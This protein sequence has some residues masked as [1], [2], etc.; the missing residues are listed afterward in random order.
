MGQF[1]D[2]ELLDF[3]RFWDL[4]DPDPHLIL[5]QLIHQLRGIIMESLDYLHFHSYE[6]TIP[7][8]T[9]LIYG[10]TGPDSNFGCSKADLLQSAMYSRART[11][12]SGQ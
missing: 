11:T 10:L 7:L 2:P 6:R 1:H 4:Q 5:D 3:L 8:L 12:A 9:P